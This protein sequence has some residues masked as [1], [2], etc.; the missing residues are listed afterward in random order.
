MEGKDF[1]KVTP[2]PLSV[3]E[4]TKMVTSPTSGAISLFIG[5]TR[6]NFD[7]K[8]VV[9]LEYE[10]Y[11]PMAEK[12]IQIICRDVRTKWNVENIAVFHRL[13]VVPVTE[14]SVIIA[15]SAP[16]R[17]P[18]LESVQ[19][20]IDTLKTTVPI[21][22]KEMFADGEGTWKENKECQWRKT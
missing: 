2:D 3:E 9:C 17:H 16:H 19:Y 14:S 5:T 20:C 6:N 8:E 4:I 21:W 10:A 18:S 7:D 13:G 11:I 15:V 22:K 1:I 12:Q